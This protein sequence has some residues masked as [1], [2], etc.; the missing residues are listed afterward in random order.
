MQEFIVILLPFSH[1]TTF[2]F[3]H[4][5]FPVR[6]YSSIYNHY[7]HESVFMKTSPHCVDWY[8][9]DLFSRRLTKWLISPYDAGQSIDV[10]M[11]AI[12]QF[13]TLTQYTAE[14]MLLPLKLR[15]NWPLSIRIMP[16]LTTLWHKPPCIRI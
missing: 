4:K 8:A 9:I 7:H 15:F 10:A 12:N 2:C 5:F 3:F 16:V 11:Q 14:N 1:S 13:R 6:P